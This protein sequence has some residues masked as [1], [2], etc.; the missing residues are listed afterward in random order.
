MITPSFDK[1]GDERGRNDYAGPE[2]EGVKVVSFGYAGQGSA[3]MRGPM[4]SGLVNQLLTTSEWGELDYLLLDMPPGTGDIHLTLG[5]VV[6]TT[7]AVVVTTPQR[8]AFI[9]VDKGVRMFAKVGS[10]VRGG[11]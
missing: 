6:P 2:Y 8:L 3:I 11:C 7:A 9:D 1:F 10:S 5:Q 4:V